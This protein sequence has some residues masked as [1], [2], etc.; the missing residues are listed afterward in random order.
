MIHRTQC[1]ACTSSECK[2]ELHVQDYTV[3]KKV[4]GIAHC[5]QCTLRFTQDI[6]E[7]D[8]IGA[9]Y[10]AESYI[11]H[12]D[13]KQGL[14]S[15]LYHLV[16]SITLKGKRNLVIS[17]TGQ[18]K[19]RLLDVGCGTGAFLNTMKISGWEVD[20]LEP[21][22]TASQIAFNNYGI[23]TK[24]P[25]AIYTLAD[26]Q[27]D[28]I[29]M[30][31]VLEHVHDL[32]GYMGRLKKL[33]KPN[34]VL[35]I[36]VPNYTSADAQKY[37]Q[38]WAAYDVPR[39]LYHFSPQSMEVLITPYQMHIS[40]MKPMWFDSF[41]VS[42]LSEQYKHGESRLFAAVLTGFWSNV[43]ALFNHKR[44][45]SLIYIIQPDGRK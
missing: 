39:H 40:K 17:S 34:G 29:T 6:P 44:C 43:K 18:S 8:E 33:L 27:Y 32:Q 5:R 12:T 35:F 14:V 30:W 2:E 36:A 20:G 15:R 23:E 41:Y 7:A 11:S 9:Y 4:F 21:D 24:H 19:G 25:Q 31:H 45:S 16:R 1:P 26:G 3:S 42:M 22:D 38:H 37:Q 28:A 13:T 10:K